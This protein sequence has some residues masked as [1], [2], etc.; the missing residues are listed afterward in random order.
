VELWAN[1]ERAY[2]HVEDVGEESRKGKAKMVEP[3]ASKE[4]ILLH[5]LLANLMGIHN[6]TRDLASVI[7]GSHVNVAA[8]VVPPSCLKGSIKPLVSTTAKHGAAFEKTSRDGSQSLGDEADASPA[9][10]IQAAHR[11]SAE[12]TKGRGRSPWPEQTGCCSR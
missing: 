11:V 3:E 4:T 9:N 12:G 8:L 1:F 7:R 6:K 10:R 5:P 2:E